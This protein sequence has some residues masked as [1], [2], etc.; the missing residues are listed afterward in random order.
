MLTPSAQ[1]VLVPSNSKGEGLAGFLGG[2]GVAHGSGCFMGGVNAQVGVIIL[3]GRG[4]DEDEVAHEVA[5][6]VFNGD[7]SG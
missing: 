6:E 2:V 4:E 7:R 5:H 3:E 1:V